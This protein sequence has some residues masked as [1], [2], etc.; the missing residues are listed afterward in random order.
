MDSFQTIHPIPIV[1]SH[2]SEDSGK[3]STVIMTR[4]NY[5]GGTKLSKLPV[6][7]G[8]SSPRFLIESTGKKNVFRDTDQSQIPP[9]VRK[10]A[11]TRE[12]VSLFG[13]PTSKIVPQSTAPDLPSIKS[14]NNKENHDQNGQKKPYKASIGIDPIGPR[15]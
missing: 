7:E 10:S 14:F 5:E 8:A 15:F 9:K 1:T 11:K 13:K 2:Q 4:K 6:K 3:A 12:N